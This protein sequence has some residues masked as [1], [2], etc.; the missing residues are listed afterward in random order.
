[1]LAG[2]A[3]VTTT[4]ACGAGSATTEAEGG[5]PEVVAAFYPLQWLTE[6][7][8]GSDVQVT[9]LTAP[10]VEPHDLELGIQQVTAVRNAALTVY[11][12]GV[13]PAVDD[14]VEPDTSF[15]AATAVKTIPAAGG[16]AEEH[17]H[18]EEGAEEHEHEVAYDP[19]LWLDP[20]RLA[21]VATKLG[22]RLAA[23]DAPRAKAYQ[24]R[25]AKTAAALGTL[26]QELAQ[27]LGTCKTR[28]LVT[29]HEAFGYLADRY[30]LKQVGITLDPETEP[31]PT[32]ISEVAKL[33]K[34]EGV[35]T[36]F[37]ETLVSPKVAEVLASQVGA[38]TAVLDPL[39]SKPSGDYMS[40]MRDNL[41]TLQTALGCTA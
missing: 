34:A 33:A 2:A 6:Q 15:D 40:A 4:A 13:Q 23:A 11:V 14:A 8:G 32:R 1:M 17:G 19:H 28:T 16:H 25:A 31:S 41:R 10:G 38:R 12:K 18:A 35:T 3:L 39:E 7:V 27:G 5:R 24:D 29:A 36:I 20:S 26:D 21:T 37:T 9:S 30:K 22:E